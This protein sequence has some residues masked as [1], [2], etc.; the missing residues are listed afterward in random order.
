MTH[1]IPGA[2]NRM[3]P[4]YRVRETSSGHQIFR[5]I[6]F[7]HG[8]W[9]PMDGETYPAAEKAAERRAVLI[10]ETSPSM[11]LSPGNG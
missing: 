11:I 9:E 10:A 7:P 4:L 8:V 6:D 5:H 3:P 1:H 2:D